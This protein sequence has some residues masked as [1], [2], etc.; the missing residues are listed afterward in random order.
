VGAR[1]KIE[2]MLVQKY[3][4]DAERLS[5]GATMS[6]LGLDSLSLAELVF[7][8]EDVFGIDIPADEAEFTTFGE[9][10]AL[11]DRHLSTRES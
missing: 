6:D 2:E 7:D 3:G 10:V 4:V 11:V 5:P 1:A 8:I 9:A